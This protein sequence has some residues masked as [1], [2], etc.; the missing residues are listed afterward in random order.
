MAQN[1]SI[2]PNNAAFVKIKIRSKWPIHESADELLQHPSHAAMSGRTD[3][4]QITERLWKRDHPGHVVGTSRWETGQQRLYESFSR[5]RSSGSI[6]SQFEMLR[7]SRTADSKIPEMKADRAL[8]R[9]NVNANLF[10]TI[11]LNRNQRTKTTSNPRSRT[12][13]RPPCPYYTPRKSSHSKRFDAAC[14]PQ[15]T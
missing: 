3:G 7:C 14:Q 10:K 11:H 1:R 6:S 15:T 5:D 4:R 2:T 13:A 8:T 12:R 9:E